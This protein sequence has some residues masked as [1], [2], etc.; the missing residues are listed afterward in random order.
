MRSL[1]CS[2]VVVSLFLF[3][4]T[5]RAEGP[6]LTAATKSL[7]SAQTHFRQCQNG[8]L[9]AEFGGALAR[10]E[11]SRRQLEKGRR[12]AESVR[13]SL[14]TVRQR[15]EAAHHQKHGSVAEREAKEARYQQAL[16]TEYLEPMKAVPPLL[17]RYAEGIERYAAVMETYATFCTTSGI[18]TASARQFVAG[19]EPQLATLDTSAQAL[20]ADA[21]KTARSD[22]AGR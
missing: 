22:V 19:L 15:V 6:A 4:T 18:T 13:R 7:A 8:K 17:A 20:L 10:L 14:E 12:E 21:R 9:Q 1:L 11:S 2:T 3:S 5:A 16:T